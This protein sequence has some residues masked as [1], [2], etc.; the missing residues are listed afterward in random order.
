M[1]N[2][3]QSDPV[4]RENFQFWSFS[5]ATGN[6]TAFSPYQLRQAIEGAVHK[7]DPH[8]EDPALQ[9]IVLIGHSQGGLLANGWR[10]TA[11]LVAA[12]SDKPPEALHLSEETRIL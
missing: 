12:L 5:Y 4:I 10:S 11:G 1:I 6:P 7:L 3:L 9:Q 2:D 8:G